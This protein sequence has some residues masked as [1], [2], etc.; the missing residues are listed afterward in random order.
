MRSMSVMAGGSLS[1]LDGL[2]RQN[3][4]QE[5]AQISQAR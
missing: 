4:Q 3:E 2:T 1:S 5:G